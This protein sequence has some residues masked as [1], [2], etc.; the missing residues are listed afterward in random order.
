VGPEYIEKININA[1][2]HVEKRRWL[3]TNWFD[4]L[5]TRVYYDY[6]KGS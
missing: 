1:K 3:L 6:E 5:K 4:E 2:R